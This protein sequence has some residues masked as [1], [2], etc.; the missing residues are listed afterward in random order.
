MTSTS[1]CPNIM[2]SKKVMFGSTPF[3]NT[4]LF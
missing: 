1:Q 2:S 4:C 3:N